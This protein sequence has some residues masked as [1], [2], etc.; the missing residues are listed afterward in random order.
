[1][2]GPC[3]AHSESSGGGQQSRGTHFCTKYRWTWYIDEK[4][5][6][7]FLTY[8][9]FLSG[10][11]AKSY[12]RKG[13]LKYEEMHKYFPIYEEAVS[14]IWLCNCSILNILI[15]EENWFFNQ[16]MYVSCATHWVLD[17]LL[18]VETI[19]FWMFY[20]LRLEPGELSFTS[21]RIIG[22]YR[23]SS[24]RIC[25]LQDKNTGLQVRPVDLFWPPGSVGSTTLSATKSAYR[26]LRHQPSVTLVGLNWEN[27][28]YTHRGIDT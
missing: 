23:V 24:S 7:I 10:A 25:S 5:N 18:L 13:F 11:V 2:F 14:H 26:R 27:K 22:Q 12:M 9:Q 16:C 28:Q 4:E 6:E 19:A 1:M 17:Y 15:Y 21:S 3:P 8:K 20:N